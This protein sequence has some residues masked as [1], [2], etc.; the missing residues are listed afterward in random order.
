MK[1]KETVKD[2]SFEYQLLDRLRSDCEY[3]LS[4]GNRNKKYLWAGDEK[5][6]IEK[7]KQLYKTLPK[8]LKPSW[9]SFKDIK[10]YE[11]RMKNKKGIKEYLKWR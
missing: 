2:Y 6:Q 1:I 9:I 11:K 4:N 7:M 10:K 3:Y 5:K 8:G